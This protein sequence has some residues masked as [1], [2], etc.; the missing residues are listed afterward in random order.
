[1]V[2]SIGG[3]SETSPLVAGMVIASQQ[4]QKTP[5]NP[6]IYKL[7]GR[8]IRRLEHSYEGLCEAGD[9]AGL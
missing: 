2:E 9:F 8:G 1:M 4:G 3:P 7:C 6:A 5:F